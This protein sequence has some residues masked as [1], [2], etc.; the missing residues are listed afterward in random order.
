MKSSKCWQPLQS[1]HCSIQRSTRYSQPT[2]HRMDSEP[3][4]FSNSHKARR[5]KTCCIHFKIHD[6]NWAA[7]CSDRKRSLSANLGV[8]RLFRLSWLASSFTS[9][10]ITSRWYQSSARKDLT[11]FHWQI[12]TGSSPPIN[13]ICAYKKKKEEG[14]SLGTR[15]FYRSTPLQN[16]YTQSELLMDRK[17]RTTVPIT[18]EQRRPKVPDQQSLRAWEEEIKRNQKKNFDSWRGVRNL[19]ELEE[20]DLVW[21]PDWQ[22]EEVVQEDVS[23]RSYN[24]STPDGTVRLNRRDLVQI[25]ERNSNGETVTLSYNDN[26]WEEDNLSTKDKTSE[27]IL[28][29]MC[30]LFGGSTVTVYYYRPRWWR[31]IVTLTS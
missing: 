20:G 12:L 9:T 1:L 19:P 5:A 26:L 23:P 27:V 30:P 18:R 4:Y 3:Y 28:S 31:E 21:I 13:Y 17:L 8:W 22:T 11:N 14:E 16:G 15:L 24:V 7:L 6:H 10:R 2:H 29:P 25:P